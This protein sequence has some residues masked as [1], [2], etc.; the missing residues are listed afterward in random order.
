MT[1]RLTWKRVAVALAALVALAV[2][3]LYSGL[4]NVAASSGH[5]RATAWLLHTAMRSSVRT[6]AAFTAP[7][8]PATTAS[9]VAA[10]G[11][12]HRS[13]AICHGAP[14]RPPSPVMRGATPPAPNLMERAS[15]WS[16]AQLFWIL[17]HGVK[18]TGM[19]AW[20]VQDREDE[21]RRM[22]GFVRLLPRITEAQYAAL[23]RPDAAAAGPGGAAAIGNCAGC[24]G[25]DGR[26]RG[27]P[28]IPILAGQSERYLA[29]TLRD[30][31]SGGRHSGIMWNVAFMLS[32]GDI[33]G[34]ARAYAA[35]P[36]V[37]D[38]PPPGSSAAARVALAG[39]PRE[40]LPACVSC[41]S[42]AKA[43]RYPRLAGQKAAYIA[44]R[45]REFRGDPKVPDDDKS[46]APMPTIARRIPEELIDPL[47]AYWAGADP[48]R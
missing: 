32:D 30:Y 27:A 6:H 35:M 33:A 20:P 48:A 45:L 47:A 39:L 5:W 37:S 38:T 46:Q 42:A 9:L 16:D 3:F 10:A 1:I 19:P 18:Y 36:G 41:H 44:Q 2:A 8:D 24:H 26:G 31:R 12:F 17:Q 21:V 15:S 22:A 7:K 4:F 40:Q 14:G 11:H 25:M 29:A 23:V 13:C 34:L 28:D 43:D